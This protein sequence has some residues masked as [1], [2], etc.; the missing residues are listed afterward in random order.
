M[1]SLKTKRN[2]G[3][4]IFFYGILS[5]M[6]VGI[7]SSYPQKSF[8]ETL[9]DIPAPPGGIN[10]EG[11][12]TT[13]PNSDS[14][15]YQGTDVRMQYV[16]ISEEKKDQ[17]GAIWSTP[18]NKM[19]LAEDFET[20]MYIYFGNQGGK[21]ADGMAFVMHND[22]RGVDS[23]GLK[24]ASIGVWAEGNYGAP[25]DGAIQNSFAVEFDPHFN[26]EFDGDLKRNTHI[27]W[28][29]PAK[30][31][32]YKDKKHTWPTANERVLI[33]NDV[34]YP[35][36]ISNGMWHSFTIKWETESSQLTYQFDEQ[37]AVVVP[38]N[39]FDVFNPAGDITWDRTVYWGFTGSTGAQFET[40]LVAFDEI[41]GLI[42]GEVSEDAVLKESY[43][44]SP[45]IENLAQTG[46]SI[47]DKIVLQHALIENSITV[48]YL[49]GRSE[50]WQDVIVQKTLS[51][52]LA[53]QADTLEIST[54]GGDHFTKLENDSQYWEGEKLIL[55]VGDLTAQRN[56]IVIRF[57]SKVKGVEEN[58][59][60]TAGGTWAD[61]LNYN[62]Y[63]DNFGYTIYE[64]TAPILTL[65]Y[66]KEFEIGKNERFSLQGTWQDFDSPYVRFKRVVTKLDA[67]GNL[68]EP[69]VEESTGKFY[70]NDAG[71]GKKNAIEGISFVPSVE[72]Y[73]SGT[74]NVKLW[75]VDYD[76]VD[77]DGKPDPEFSGTFAGKPS[78]V[79]EANVTIVGSL[80]F[81]G[82]SE[83][84]YGEESIPTQRKLIF[85]GNNPEIKVN[86]NRGSG[87]NWEL[88]LRMK[89][90]LKATDGQENTSLNTYYVEDG[91]ET[92]VT[93]EW[94]PIRTH[95]TKQDS[96]YNVA[97]KENEGV[98]IEINNF[99]YATN[100]T[101]TLSWLLSDVPK[102]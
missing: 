35:G 46:E 83:F 81:G 56:K 8:G 33:H 22:P 34:Q 63:E 75:L 84:K 44:A 23:L 16:V 11:V 31:S 70:K 62:Q 74:Y 37:S 39:V 73:D 66:P 90:Y 57:Q 67:D 29:Y 27:A 65:N 95:T 30:Q 96:S 78:Q 60:V 93:K 64:N 19:D 88:S 10:L 101:G 12:F 18:T 72:G 4:P 61:G 41:P 13:P 79:F 45:A 26:N 82:I 14:Q 86:D 28:N 21:A 47:K 49:G 68:E 53:Y 54:D 38:I 7:F 77:E 97:W 69:G 71:F 48:E 98:A 102:E 76:D 100:Y 85:P 9:E 36:N 55:P 25:L 20:K 17:I 15:V 40:N 52:C 2:N 80:E 94:L 89:A 5:V 92:L 50:V 43:S 24:G 3:M 51:G 58:T 32:S 6:I 1:I 42:Q 59:E 99:N 87:K 91:Q